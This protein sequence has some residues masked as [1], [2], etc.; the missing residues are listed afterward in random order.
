MSFDDVEFAHNPDPRCP[1]V[2]VL[3]CSGSMADRRDGDSVSPIDALQQGLVRLHE[4]LAADPLAS[5]RAELAVV[6]F[7]EQVAVASDFSTVDNW[8]IPRL[9]ASG[10]TPMGAAVAQALEL[11]EQRKRT[12]RQNGVTYYRPW[13]LLITD[14]VPTDDITEAAAKVHAAEGSKKVACFTVAVEGA[15]LTVLSKLSPRAPMKLSGTKFNELFVWLSASQARVSA[16]QP[17]DA[18][19]LPSPAGWAEV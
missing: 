11:L 6:T 1:V 2:L 19:P 15:D 16:S 13:M 17:G 18:V 9:V 12:Y 14:G 7:G 4:E 10:P 5:R 3:D 8:Q